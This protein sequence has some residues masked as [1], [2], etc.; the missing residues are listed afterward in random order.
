ML[1]KQL[2]H[3]LH[4]A[5]AVCTDFASGEAFKSWAWMSQK[6]AA[7][8]EVTDEAA[9]CC[10]PTNGNGRSMLAGTPTYRMPHHPR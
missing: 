2:M 7:E 9:L 5:Q 3:L 6:D 4:V 8:V 1:L 10:L